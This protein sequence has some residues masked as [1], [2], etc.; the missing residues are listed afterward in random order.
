MSRV[1]FG[2]GG[3]T[4]DL[5]KQTLLPQ[6]LRGLPTGLPAVRLSEWPRHFERFVVPIGLEMESTDLQIEGTAPADAP[7]CL[8]ACEA[9]QQVRECLRQAGP[10]RTSR[11]RA[12]S[13]SGVNGFF[14]NPERLRL[15]SSSATRSSE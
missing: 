3:V 6:K 13:A 2:G 14:R 7:R 9:L 15:A 8:G 5:G 11:T 12:S 1:Q 4:V 10:S